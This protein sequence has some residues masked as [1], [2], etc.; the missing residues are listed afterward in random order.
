M[1]TAR[2]PPPLAWCYLQVNVHELGHADCS[3]SYVFRGT[4]DYQAKSVQ[5]LLGLAL[6]R[7][8]SAPNQPAPPSALG[9]HR[10]QHRRRRAVSLSARP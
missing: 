4:K 8:Q 10:Y 6:G 5:D 9:A 3:K 2:A 7:T 1:L